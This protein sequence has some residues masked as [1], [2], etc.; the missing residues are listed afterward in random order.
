MRLPL[1]RSAAPPLTTA[2]LSLVALDPTLLT[3]MQDGTPGPGGFCWPAGWPDEVDRAHLT[4][5]LERAPDLDGCDEWR[6]RAVVDR[7]GTMVGHAGFHRP[8]RSIDE[9]LA[10]PTFTG[11]TE[12]TG[13]GVVEIG[14]TTFPAERRRGYATEAVGALV[15][16]ALARHDVSAVLATA[17]EDNVASKTVL[18]RVGGFRVIG[19]CFD[20]DGYCETVFRRDG[21]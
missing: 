10:D 2:R 4:M 11:T 15:D 5:W 7:A 18:E 6:P 1:V 21:D 3:A 16:W 19:T 14:Y 8:P 17:A 20:D 9:A 12:P 13:R